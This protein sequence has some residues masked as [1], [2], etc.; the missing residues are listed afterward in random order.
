MKIICI[1]RNYVDHAR[2]LNNPVPENPVFF[3]KP[4]TALLRRNR[5]FYYP[6]FSEDIHYECELVVKINKLGKNIQK[7]FAH[8]YYNEIGIGIDFTARDLQAKAKAKGLPW[9]IAKAFDAS[10]P[11]SMEFINK[12]KIADLNDIGFHLDK[13]GETVQEGNSAD[14]IFDFDDLIA[15]LS[16]FFTLKTGDLIFTGTPAGVGPIRIGDKLEAY[17]GDRLLLKCNIK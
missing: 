14:M 7:K 16:K 3:L 12:D 13:N 4:D 10:A 17:I 15:Y 1:G 5:P 2:E 8:T 9:E 6:D 11:L